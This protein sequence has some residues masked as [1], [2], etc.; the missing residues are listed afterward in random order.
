MIL[1]KRFESVCFT[2]IF[3]IRVVFDGI[4]VIVTVLY[5]F[6][7]P[8]H[9]FS[10]VAHFRIHAGNVIAG[11]RFGRHDDE[12]FFKIFDGQVVF[13][14]G[15]MFKCFLVQFFGGCQVWRAFLLMIG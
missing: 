10:D 11:P 8:V 12:D 6:G 14:P 7:K 13:T 1:D 3:E 2:N 4:P 5:R 15:G 9:G